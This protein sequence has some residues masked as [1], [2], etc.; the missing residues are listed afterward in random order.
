[1]ANKTNKPLA[2][3]RVPLNF[4]KTAAGNEPVLEWLRSLP[5]AERKA[6]GSDLSDAQFA[7]P[8]GMPLCR[9]LG[10][11]LFEIRTSLNDKIARVFVC[12]SDGGLV[13]LHGLIKKTQKI[14]ASD[15]AL[16]RKRM[17]DLVG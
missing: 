4:Y 7:W 14:P 11:H 12:F 13:A 8:V 16:A 3:Q 10:S 15:L 2:G 9:P 17:K 5:D 1:M 6:I